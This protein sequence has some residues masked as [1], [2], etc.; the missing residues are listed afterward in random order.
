MLPNASNPQPRTLVQRR[1]L[2]YSAVSSAERGHQF[3]VQRCLVPV[4][5]L[6]RQYKVINQDLR[7]AWLQGGHEGKE[8]LIVDRVGPVLNDAVEDVRSCTCAR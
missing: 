4:S 2:G 7:V 6:V 1:M 3:P 5:T 8:D